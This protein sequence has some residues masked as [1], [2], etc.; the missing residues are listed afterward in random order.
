MRTRHVYT[1]SGLTRYK[2]RCMEPNELGK[3]EQD[4][5]GQR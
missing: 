3:L 2:L 1:L 5:V 4:G